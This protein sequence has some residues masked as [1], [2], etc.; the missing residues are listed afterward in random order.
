MNKKIIALLIAV[1]TVFAGCSGKKAENNYDIEIESNVTTDGQTTTEQETTAEQFEENTTT[2]TTTQVTTKAT[3]KDD[4]AVNSKV[5]NKTKEIEIKREEIKHTDFDYTYQAEDGE[6]S[7]GLKI[8]NSMEGYS[9][10]GYVSGFAPQKGEVKIIM[11]SSTAQHYNIVIKVASE[12]PTHNNII[13]GDGRTLSFNATGSG[14]FEN[15]IFENIYIEEGKTDIKVQS[16][17][18]DFVLDKISITDTKGLDE[19][20]SAISDYKLSNEKASKKTQSIYKFISETCGKNIISG[21]YNTFSTNAETD[22]IFEQTGKYPAI[23]FSDFMNVTSDKSHEEEF[24]LAKKYNEDG[25]IIGYVWHWTDPNEH[26]SFYS[27]DTKFDI[28]KAVTTEDIAKS[29]TDEIKKLYDNKK[30]SEE[31]YKIILDIDTASEQLKKYKDADITVL[32]RPLHEASGGWF[33][34]GTDKD[35]Y[36]WLWKLM[37]TRMTQYHNLDN[38]IW[39]WNGESPDWYVGD[40]YCDILSADIYNEGDFSVHINSLKSLHAIS[41][42]KPCILSE[43]GVSP[44]VKN[45]VRDNALW[46]IVGQWGGEFLIDEYGELTEKYT[47]N[48]QLSDYYNNNIVITRDKLPKF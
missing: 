29:S 18:G 28:K 7:D 33:W 45:L 46:G 4:K 39:I 42:S 13:I 17:E 34:W 12:K 2:T 15:F 38:L 35:S 9:G 26:K 3:T 14:E 30:I 16:D 47:S 10:G 37:Y 48:Q 19:F 41:G 6:L 32:W 25:G 23:R 24:S 31:C 36:I 20:S 40:E 43:C 44:D 22:A 27:K 8:E 1:C 11:E 21:Q 5:D